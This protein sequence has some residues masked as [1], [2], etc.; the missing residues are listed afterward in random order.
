M[1]PHFDNKKQKSW[2]ITFLSSSIMSISSLPFLW[3][4]L[5]SGGDVLGICHRSQLAHAICASF[6]GFL[7]SDLITGISNYPQQLSPLLGWAHH[8]AYALM[9]P[10]ITSR[11][12]AH[13][14]CVCLSME[15]PTCVI[16]TSFLW[17]RLR[18]DIFCALVFFSTRII[19][20]LAL[21]IE[22]IQPRGRIEAANGSFMPACML[23]I[24]FMM[25]VS[26][27]YSSVK[28]IIR[29]NC[30]PCPNRNDLDTIKDQ[31]RMLI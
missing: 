27:F 19:L 2:I 10:Y 24:A 12:W 6:Q 25:H 30:E 31:V 4:F 14:F 28:G 15:I 5:S 3:D 26:W 11:G 18:H 20:H 1:A 23:A 16:A 21:L 7:L 17:P 8:I 13:I 22:S 29:R 9:L